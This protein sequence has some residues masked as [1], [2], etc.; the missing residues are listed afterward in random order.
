MLVFSS[1]II[2]KHQP[3]N[4][5]NIPEGDY[6]CIVHQKQQQW[7]MYNTRLASDT[8]SGIICSTIDKSLECNFLHLYVSSEL[9]VPE[10][11]H[12][13]FSI[14]TIEIYTAE[15]NTRDKFKTNTLSLSAGGFYIILMGVA[16]I[17]LMSF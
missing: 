1:C 13:D 17:L 8:I 14:P 6:Y 15:I 2:Y 4:K 7:F 5:H 12:G 11:E 9:K 3:V 16:Y 10:A